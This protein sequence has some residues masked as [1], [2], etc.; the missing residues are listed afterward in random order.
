[1]DKLK[2]ET[3]I[4]HE[5]ALKF[6]AGKLMD[7]QFGDPQYMFTTT[8]DRVFFVAEKVAQ[9]IHGLKLK[10]REPFD[11]CKAEVDYGKGRKGIEWQVAKVGFAAGE[12]VGHVGEQPNGTFAVEKPITPTAQLEAELVRSLEE[13]RAKQAA[14]GVTAPAPVATAPANAAPQTDTGNGSK[15][16]GNGKG[17]PAAAST[18]NGPLQ[19][20]ALFL[21]SQTNMLIDVYALACKHA[22]EHHG[23]LVKLETVQSLVVTA[24]IDL[25]KKGGGPDVA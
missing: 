13:L 6:P 9:K 24:F 22:S 8:E 20:W 3:N 1:M 23:N 7:S 2:F 14:A 21:L 12:A 5:I 11:I 18:S 15:G 4:N 16:N 17:K 19:P 10:P 25:G